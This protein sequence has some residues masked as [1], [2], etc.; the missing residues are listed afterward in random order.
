MIRSGV[1]E[2]SSEKKED[3]WLTAEFCHSRLTV[4]VTVAVCDIVPLFPVIVSV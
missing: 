1:R 3:G 4:T 2:R